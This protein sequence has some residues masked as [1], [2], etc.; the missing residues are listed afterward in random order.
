MKIDDIFTNE[1]CFTTLL[2]AEVVRFA[3]YME[4]EIEVSPEAEMQ[5]IS[6]KKI[7]CRES[8]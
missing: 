8:K 5:L 2:V 1:E 4:Q 6:T 7:P 3:K